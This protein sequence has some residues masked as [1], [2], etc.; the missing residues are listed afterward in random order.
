MKQHFKCVVQPRVF[1]LVTQ[2][3]MPTVHQYV[4]IGVLTTEDP[5]WTFESANCTVLDGKADG[6]AEALIKVDP[7]SS[8]TKIESVEAVTEL[9]GR[10]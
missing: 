5:V 4:V 1:K 6:L 10:F 7:R 2:T 9:L 8:P 3:G